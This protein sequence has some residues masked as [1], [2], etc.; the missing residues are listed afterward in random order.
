MD[1]KKENGKTLLLWSTFFIYN[2]NYACAL[3]FNSDIGR[4]LFPNNE[5]NENEGEKRYTKRAI[6]T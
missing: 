4:K 3:T 1:R 6:H 5:K 2:E